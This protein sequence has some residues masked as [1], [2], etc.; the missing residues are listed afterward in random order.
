MI[1]MQT[2]FHRSGFLAFGGGGGTLAC[3]PGAFVSRTKANTAGVHPNPPPSSQNQTEQ[4]DQVTTL[5][6]FWSSCGGGGPLGR[7]AY[8]D[9]RLP[10]VE[11]KTTFYGLRVWQYAGKWENKQHQ[12][13]FCHDVF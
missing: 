3:L 6:T 9:P 7:T 1:G 13:N 10:P 2:L 8:F 12:A 4:E 5:F 11:I